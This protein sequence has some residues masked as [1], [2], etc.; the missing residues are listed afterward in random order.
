MSWYGWLLA[1][2]LLASL[3]LL[4][5]YWWRSRR[6]QRDLT[7]ERAQ[8]RLADLTAQRER[9]LRSDADLQTEVDGMD[10]KIAEVQERL[11]TAGSETFTAE[12]LA[13]AF[14][15]RRTRR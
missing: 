14:R 15:R 10:A 5:W 13:D 7:S 2:L 9:I 12:E 8:R 6:L 1:G 11:H 4:G 3:G